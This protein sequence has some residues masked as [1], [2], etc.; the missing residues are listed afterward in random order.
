MSWSVHSTVH[1]TGRDKATYVYM[2]PFLE[3]RA[4]VVGN[5][6][7][8]KM[9]QSRRIHCRGNRPRGRVSVLGDWVLYR[10]SQVP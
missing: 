8:E 6:P 9:G 1:T 10:F 4:F 7:G 3:Q 2:C 5:N